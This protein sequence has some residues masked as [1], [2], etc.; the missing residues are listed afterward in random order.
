MAGA[1]CLALTLALFVS[2]AGAFVRPEPDRPA[3]DHPLSAADIERY[4]TVFALQDEGAWEKADE[5]IARLENRALMGHV[6]AQRYLDT[7]RYRPRYRELA[8]WLARYADHPDAPAIHKQALKRKP[9]SAPAP[10]RPERTKD[11]LAAE[12]P[13]NTVYLYQSAKRMTRGDRRKVR[14]LKRRLRSYIGRSW[15]TKAEQ[16]LKRQDVGRLFDGFEMDSAQAEI[17]AGWLYLGKTEKALRL[18]DAVAARSGERI[19]TAYWTAGLA[20]WRLGETAQAGRHFARLAGSEKA[21]DWN[22]AA[23]AYWAARVHQAAP[24][25]AE[26]HRWLTVA[27]R[28]PLTFYGLLARHRLNLRPE[29]SFAPVQP[30]PMSIL[31]LLATPRGARAVGLIQVGQTARADRELLAVPGWKDPAMTRTMLALTQSGRLPRLGLE[32]AQRLTADQSSGWARRE[33]GAVMYPLPRWAPQSGFAI[34]R[35]L[36]YAFIRQESGFDPQAR[37]PDGAR[38][39]MQLMPRTAATLDRRVRSAGRHDRLLYDPA[40]NLELAQRYLRSLLD[41]Q[42]VSGDLLRLSVAYNAGPGNLRKWTR[43]MPRDGDPLLFLESLPSLESRLFVERVMTNL[44]IYRLR[45]G[46]PAPTLGALAAG[47]WPKYEPLD[48]TAPQIASEF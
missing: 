37:S 9:R 22:R 11:S 21:S 33:L 42:R 43:R 16:L 4:R 15:L 45:L 3:L 30:D 40:L 25:G 26:S 41:S 44:W 19:P 46:Q 28:F 38:G 18:A 1:L 10:H 36:I 12:T 39:L 17:A 8:A 32:I 2:P 27:A 47:R 34:D 14:R 13:L 31:R 7:K 6:L 48:R 23:G 24:D 20:A 5:R 29:V 35:A